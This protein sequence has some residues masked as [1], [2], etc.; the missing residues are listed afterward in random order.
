MV[1]FRPNL[2]LVFCLA[3]VALGLGPL[4]A[5]DTR[6][7]LVPGSQILLMDG[8]SAKVEDLQVGSVIWT[9]APPNPPVPGKITGKRPQNTDFYLKLQAGG[10]ILSATGS[11]RIA[12]EGGKLVWLN[13]VQP[14][15][16]VWVWGP[17][18][19]E[20]VPV[21]SVR[22]LPV[23]ILAW[24]LTVEGHRLFQVNGILVGD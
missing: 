13:T 15:D 12:R 18:G 1:I 3:L 8:T 23:T 21:S 7:S 24:D 9:W 10:R 5:Q 19:A 14:G 20:G 11:H 16:R 22:E 2:R 6:G 17:E 4:A